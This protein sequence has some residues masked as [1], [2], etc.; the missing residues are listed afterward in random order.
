VL[1]IIK[2][3][4]LFG[5]TGIEARRTKIS[6][7]PLEIEWTRRGAKLVGE[8]STWLNE[9]DAPAGAAPERTDE[10]IEQAGQRVRAW[11]EDLVAAF[12]AADAGPSH[13]TRVADMSPAS[14]WRVAEPGTALLQ[15]L[16]APDR[17]SVSIVLTIGDVPRERRVALAEGEL[18]RLVFALREA[19]QVRSADFLAPAQ[20]LHRILIAPVADDL[21]ANGIVTLAFW[22]DDVLRYVPMGAL[23]D[24]VRFLIETFD[25]VLAA[26]TSTVRKQAAVA[27]AA[28]LGVSRPI[29]G[30]R[31]LLAVR[32]ELA[33]IVRESEP[34]DGVLPGTVRLDEAFTAAALRQAVRENSVVHIASHFIFAAA[35][36]T[37]SYLVL[38]DGAKLTLAQ[39]GELRFD[40]VDLVVLSACNTAVGAGHRQNGREIEGLGALVHEHGARKVLA[41]LWPVA[42]FTTATLMRQF[43]R[44]T[45]QA[46][47]RP[48]QAL[49]L[50]QLA[51]LGDAASRGR[52]APTRSLVDPD[53]EQ[54]DEDAYAGTSHPFYWAPYILMQETARPALE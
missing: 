40:E 21:H 23:H 54:G 43:Y 5:L 30:C 20:Q 34:S 15:Y 25:L 26:G 38:G 28:G 7:T 4:E 10:K 29:A 39:L 51:L 53:E 12:A 9:D 17:L 22:L 27:R 50:A 24:G 16:F 32:E 1:A 41:T 14:A 36:E 8:L 52:P 37:S 3:R 49:R 19:V 42:D 44:L 47:L 6:L 33:A 31:P 45:Y 11:F 46:G 48:A 2:E 35:R 18:N 13:E